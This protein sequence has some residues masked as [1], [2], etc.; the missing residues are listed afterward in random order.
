MKKMIAVLIA[1]TLI[2]GTAVAQ[3]S[4]APSAKPTEKKQTVVPQKKDETSKPEVK[5]KHHHKGGKMQNKKTEST[6]QNK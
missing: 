2:I 3:N 5:K 1:G 6:P 4:T